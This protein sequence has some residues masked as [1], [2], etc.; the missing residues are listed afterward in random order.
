MVKIASWNVN[1]I[2]ARLPNVLDWLDAAKPD[3]VLLQEIKSVEETFP[4]LE[5]SGLGYNLAISGQKTYNGVAILSK[6]PLEIE[7]TALPGDKS[8]EQARY[9]E[10]V[11]ETDAG[12]LRVASIYLPNGNPVDTDKF[13]YKLAWMKRLE[14]HARKLLALEEPVILGGDYNVIPQDEDC[15]DPAAWKG[16]ALFRPESRSALR[17]LVNLGFTDAFRTF[18]AGPGAYTFWDYQRGAWQKDHGI[19]IDHLLLSPQA[20]DLLVECDIDRAPRG[21]PKASDHTPIWCAL[22][23]DATSAKA[24]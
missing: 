12:V 23:A 22:A 14:A 4:A 8:D 2:K 20:A 6:T 21:K 7:H 1:S 10:A 18:H 15:Y 17:R 3:I 13:D 16:D 5:I 19:R 24:A 9:V 11:T